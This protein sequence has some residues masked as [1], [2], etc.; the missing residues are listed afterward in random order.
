MS[1]AFMSNLIRPRDVDASLGGSLSL[2]FT[3]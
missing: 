3:L 2:G 1:L